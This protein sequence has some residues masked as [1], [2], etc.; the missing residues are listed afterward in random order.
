MEITGMLIL[1]KMSVGVF[2]IS[3]GATIIIR[4]ARTTNV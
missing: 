4:I 3:T 2:R 1:G